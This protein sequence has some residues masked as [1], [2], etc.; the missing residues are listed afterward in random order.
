MKNSIIALFLLIINVL[1]C[2]PIFA[3]EEIP[4]IKFNNKIYIL[5]YA[6]S[7]D[8]NN[9][10]LNEFTTNDLFYKMVV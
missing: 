7:I 4:T 8:N 9:E 1:F 5:K 3:E 10:I 6:K 2:T